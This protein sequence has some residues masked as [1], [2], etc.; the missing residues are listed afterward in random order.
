MNPSKKPMTDKA[1]IENQPSDVDVIP[2]LSH[3]TQATKNINKVVVGA[4]IVIALCVGLFLKW[5]IEGS[6]P[7]VIKNSPFPT[8]SIRTHAQPEGVIILTVDYCKNTDLKGEVRT[9]FVSESREVFMPL[10]HEQLDRGCR[11]REIP[12]LIPKDLPADDYKLKFIVRYDI[13]PLKRQVP[14]QF[15]S[16]VFH[17]D[18]ERE[19]QIE[20]QAE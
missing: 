4:L 15:E 13:N 1:R 6:D 11:K 14:A 18:P 17:V 20:P 3:P 2:E 5:S 12:V 7:L 19:Q 10:A 8:R 9:S 16:R